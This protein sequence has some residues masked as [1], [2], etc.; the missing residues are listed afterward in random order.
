MSLVSADSDYNETKL[1]SLNDI[2]V[3]YE[4]EQDKEGNYIAK[5]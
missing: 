5:G 4:F 3:V 1:T 2:V